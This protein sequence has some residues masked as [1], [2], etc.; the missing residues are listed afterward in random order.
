MVMIHLD[1]NKVCFYSTLKGSH[2]REPYLDLVNNRSQRSYLSILR[3]SA[4]VEL[5]I[6]Q[7][8]YMGK[9]LSERVC[10][11]CFTGDIGDEKHLLLN[12]PTFLTNRLCF[13]GKLSSLIPSFKNMSTDLQLRTMLCPTTTTAAKLINKYIR[14]LFDSRAR[15]DNNE[16]ILSYPTNPTNVNC[17][18]NFS[19]YTDPTNENCDNI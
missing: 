12:C 8:R 6:E 18:S 2:T 15:L 16:V 14:I 10:N 1:H 17:D 13:I 9:P 11:Y 19:F 7:G 4:S 3:M 5:E